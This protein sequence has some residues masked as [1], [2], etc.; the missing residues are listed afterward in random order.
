[1]TTFTLTETTLRRH[2][3]LFI[4]LLCVLCMSDL[5]A[6]QRYQSGYVIG[7]NGR[8]TALD[9]E[10]PDGK[11]TPRQVR[12]KGVDGTVRV[13]DTAGIAE[14]GIG[15]AV[16]RYTKF[17]VALD[18]STKGIGETV[19]GNAPVFRDRS[20]LLEHLVDGPLQLFYWS[21]GAA[22]AYFVRHGEEDT[23][24]QLIYR[25]YTFGQRVK[26]D[27]RYIAQLHPY[28]C[29]GGDDDQL[30]VPRFREKELTDFVASYN[31][32]SGEL[33]VFYRTDKRKIV[34][35]IL[36]GAESADVE[37]LINDGPT[38]PLNG[39]VSPRF[40]LEAEMTVP[41]TRDMLAVHAQAY[42]RRSSSNGMVYN[43]ERDFSYTSVG[44]LLGLRTYSGGDRIR[45]FASAAGLIDFPLEANIVSSQQRFGST[46]IKASPNAGAVLGVGVELNRP[47]GLHLSRQLKRNV[48]PGI[49]STLTF[50]RAWTAEIAY[51]V[52]R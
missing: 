14:F 18:I 12:V 36:A 25:R 11:S 45:F 30:G 49:G 47:L 10:I 9:I 51:A 31:M 4:S 41:Y 6:Q 2:S 43:T 33:P 40:A 34:V 28:R 26:T 13:L 20:L 27:S 44:T 32:C 46:I 19:S 21:D 17:R 50:Y 42:V 39:A 29:V 1:M 38:W 52:F 35:K 37:V 7:T 15:T 23:P 16:K 8:R 24:R 48:T 3:Y 5:S 22:E